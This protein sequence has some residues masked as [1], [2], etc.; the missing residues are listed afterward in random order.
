MPLHDRFIWRT[1]RVP[2][3]IA[4]ASA[5]SKKKKMSTLTAEQ[6]LGLAIGGIVCGILAVLIGISLIVYA[7]CRP[8]VYIH[9]PA[10]E[11][12]MVKQQ[13]IVNAQQRTRPALY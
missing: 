4:P 3:P 13:I 5:P 11:V 12:E 9:V 8:R 10:N 6:Q 1:V 7:S 2:S